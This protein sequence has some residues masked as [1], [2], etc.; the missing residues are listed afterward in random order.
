MSAILTALGQARF[1]QILW[2][3][4]L[5]EERTLPALWCA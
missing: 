2:L 5:V 1:L 3:F 4:P